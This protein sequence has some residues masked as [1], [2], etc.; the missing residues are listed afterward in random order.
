[1]EVCHGKAEFGPE[2]D[3]RPRHARV[4][5]WRAGKQPRREGEEPA[6]GG[7]DRAERGR[8][9]EP[10]V[11]AAEP[12]PAVTHQVERAARGDCAAGERGARRDG[13]RW[14]HVAQAWR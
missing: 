7:G 13:A 2:E 1:M 5:A 11:A 3:C 4:E 6:P 8:F 14:R 9:F 10:A 12:T